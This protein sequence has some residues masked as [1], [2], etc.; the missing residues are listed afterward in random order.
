MDFKPLTLNDIDIVKPYFE[1]S[2]WKTC[3]YTVG[4]MF[5]WRDFYHMEYTIVNNTFFSRMYHNGKVFYNIPLSGDLNASLR[6]LINSEGLPMKFCTVPKPLL[7]LFEEAGTNTVITEQRE[8]S[9]YLYSSEDLIHLS[10]KKYSGQRNQISQ[11]KRKVESWS[12]HTIDKTSIER[13][14]KFFMEEYLPTAEGGAYEVEENQ[15]VLEL[16]EHYDVFQMIG[17]YL[18]ADGEIVGFSIH[19]IIGDTMFTHV[20]KASR[21]CKGAHQM[22]VNQSVIAFAGDSVL[23]INREED[24][25][26]PGLIISKRSYHPIRLLEKYVVEVNAT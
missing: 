4:G 15:K 5:M 13:I 16:L 22:L 10:G 11:F 8:L 19:E 1:L 12:F 2:E 17:G 9:D 23:Y 18:V 7:P 14:R 3:D 26:D 25:G 6:F 24:M 20:E 21:K